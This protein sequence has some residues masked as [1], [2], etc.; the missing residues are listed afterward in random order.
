VQRVI[1]A[2]D[3]VPG[4]WTVLR[5]VEVKLFGA[6]VAADAE[7]DPGHVLEIDE[8]GLLVACGSGGVRVGYAQPAG[9]RRLAALDWAQGRGVA[10]GDVLGP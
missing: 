10:A 6:R 4:A 3:P 2:F 1:R 5:D 9:K 7:G 8:M